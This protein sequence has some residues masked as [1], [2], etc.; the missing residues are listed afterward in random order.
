MKNKLFSILIIL[1]PITT[2]FSTTTFFQDDIQQI[3]NEDSI[4][5][6]IKIQPTRKITDKIIMAPY[7]NLYY[8]TNETRDTSSRFYTLVA[9]PLACYYDDEEQHLAPL[10]IKD[11]TTMSTSVTRFLRAYNHNE[12]YE[13][14][15][16]DIETISREIATIFWKKSDVILA[17]ENTDQGYEDGLI[18]AP[19]ASYLNVP[20]IIG[21][22]TQ[23]LIEQLEC[24]EVIL[25]GD[26]IEKPDK[27]LSTRLSGRKTI[28]SY[29]LDICKLKIGNIK[30]ISLANPLDA[31]P[32]HILNKS[33]LSYS[34]GIDYAKP[35]GQIHPIEPQS[36]FSFNVPNGNLIIKFNLK[37]TPEEGAHLQTGNLTPNGEGFKLIF[38][39]QEGEDFDNNP[40]MGNGSLFYTDSN[41][42]DDWEAYYEIDVNNNSG[43]YY[44]KLWGYGTCNKKWKLTITAEKIDANIRPQAPYLSTLAPYLAASHCGIVIADKKFSENIAGKIGDIQRR[45]NVTLNDA[46]AQAACED[47]KYTDSVLDGTLHQIKDK[48]LYEQYKSDN[49]YLGIIADNNMI[50]MYYYPSEAPR[51]H[52]TYEG[53]YQPSDNRLADIDG[54]GY[55]LTTRLEL[56]V[57]RLM[58]WDAQDVSALIA[59]TLFYK[60]IIDK[61]EGL[62]DCDWKQSST[63]IYGLA[64]QERLVL[65]PRLTFMSTKLMLK[66]NGYEVFVKT[67][68]FYKVRYIE[69][70]LEN[71]QKSNL[72]WNEGHGRYY[73]YEYFFPIALTQL[74]YKIFLKIFYPQKQQSQYAV[75]NVIDMEMGPSV[76]AVCACIGGLTDGIPL[77]CTNA[78]ASIHAGCNAVFVNTRCPSGPMSN[79][80]SIVNPIIHAESH[81]Y[82]DQLI[83]SWFDELVKK[84]VSIGLACRNSKN[85]FA[86][87][88]SNLP[89]WEFLVK[90]NPNEFYRACEDYTHYTI[91]G[92]P[93]FN[94][95]S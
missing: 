28:M 90:I 32:I 5:H 36:L 42:Y 94:P 13:M 48:G 78:M 83:G 75:C 6:L 85:I 35:F 87:K 71:M 33:I 58:G 64:L 23:N 62:E 63:M 24:K 10:L 70:L 69:N 88:Y 12:I 11:K 41:A 18:A 81:Y 25:I 76:M 77:R 16:G 72:I 31:Q 45:Y 1:L 86:E 54:D 38:F 60:Y 21:S 93:A 43:T 34:E 44:V 84:D 15:P 37:F 50:P 2:I 30:Y 79:I 74:Y 53:T 9:T 4:C 65:G 40:E 8:E 80:G 3:Q 39:D 57:G 49:P 92:D 68:N 61:F 67:N 66:Q 7:G 17:I 26:N 91:Y 27:I 22:P 14:P 29:V 46:A 20:L 73:R 56:A 51:Q 19:L 47:N 82:Y 59:R 55:N 95:H 89:W 52:Y